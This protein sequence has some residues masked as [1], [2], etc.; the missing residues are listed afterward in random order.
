MF[1]YLVDLS[2]QPAL[3]IR[4]VGERK[5]RSEGNRRSRQGSRKAKAREP[6]G[7]QDN[8]P[9][10]SN[11]LPAEIEICNHLSGLIQEDLLELKGLKLYIAPAA[12]VVL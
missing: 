7:A 6:K 4:I 9:Q 2:F 11:E 5:Q 10:Q 12:C 3:Y 1:I 8:G